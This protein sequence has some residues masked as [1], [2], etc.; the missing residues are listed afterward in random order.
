MREFSYQCDEDTKLCSP[1]GKALVVSL[2]SGHLA[3]ILLEGDEE[4]QTFSAH[5]YEPWITAFDKSD[6]SAMTVW[7]GGDDLVLKKWDLEQTFRPSL[8]NKQ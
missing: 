8:V 7:S 1:A 2:S 6:D 4:I 5:M 3:H